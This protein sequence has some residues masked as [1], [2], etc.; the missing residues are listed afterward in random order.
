MR[1]NTSAAD[2]LQQL[3]LGQAARR[4]RALQQFRRQFALGTVQVHDPFLDAVGHHQP[5]DRDRPGLADTVG[6]V[7]RLVLHRRIPPRIEMHDIVRRGQVQAST[8]GTQADQEQ[9]G[10]AGLEC[11]HAAL[12]WNASSARPAAHQRRAL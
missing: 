3:L 8:A 11:R 10:L 6:A 7:G 4:V 1:A 5:V 9:V 12:T 2:Q